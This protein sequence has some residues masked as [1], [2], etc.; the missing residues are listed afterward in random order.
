[1]LYDLSIV[2]PGG[3]WWTVPETST[4]LH[5]TTFDDLVEKTRVHYAE[6]G[7]SYGTAL[8]ERV[9]Q[10]ICDRLIEEGERGF[11]AYPPPPVEQFIEPLRSSKGKRVR[12]VPHLKKLLK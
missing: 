11:C 7:Y 2:P 10:G 3:W 6:N 1:M 12:D 9:N 5:G 4:P 8:E